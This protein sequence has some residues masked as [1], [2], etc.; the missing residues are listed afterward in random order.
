[1]SAS[2]APSDAPRYGE[3]GHGGLPWSGGRALGASVAVVAVIGTS[4]ELSDL[5]RAP[6]AQSSRS[7]SAQ[8]I[9]SAPD[10]A[11]LDRMEPYSEVCQISPRLRRAFLP[12]SRTTGLP[13]PLLVAVAYEESKLR[14]DARSPAGARGLFQ[15]M[16]ATARE[17]G[18]N[19]DVPRSNIL[20]GARYLEQMTDRFGTLDLSLAAYKVGPTALEAG[21]GQI[22]PSTQTYIGNVRAHAARTS[23][24]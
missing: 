23:C 21:G 4:M 22:P 19:P 13:L 6:G 9:A 11:A 12:A 16:P 14:Q 5:D 17:L 18:L 10:G 2:R 15:L 7:A 20:A 3:L 8:T 24:R 1:M